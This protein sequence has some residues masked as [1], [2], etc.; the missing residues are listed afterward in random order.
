MVV[1]CGSW[2]RTGVPEGGVYRALDKV[3][4]QG[5][6][7]RQCLL[8]EVTLQLPLCTGVLAG[9]VLQITSFPMLSHNLLLRTGVPEG[10]ARVRLLRRHVSPRHLPVST[11]EFYIETLII[12]EL[13]SRKITT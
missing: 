12:Y 7:K 5:P 10:G 6:R 8:S 9:N 11:P 1:V 4:L 13:R 2:P 3:L